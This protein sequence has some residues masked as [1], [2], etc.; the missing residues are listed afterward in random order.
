MQNKHK[1]EA[2][3]M[4]VLLDAL[5]LQNVVGGVDTPC[6]APQE[7]SSEETPSFSQ[8]GMTPAFQ[9]IPWATFLGTVVSYGMPGSSSVSYG[10]P[11]SSS[12]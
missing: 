9:T 7:V 8:T 12:K 10:M 1:H 2:E 11:G 5:E 6:T 3:Q 4:A